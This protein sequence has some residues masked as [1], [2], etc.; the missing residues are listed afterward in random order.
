M[1]EVDVRVVVTDEDLLAVFD[2]LGVTVRVEEA[3]FDFVIDGVVEIVNDG[4]EGGSKIERNPFPPMA[5]LGPPFET[6]PPG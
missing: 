2:L 4:V 5:P 3:E 1:E 6:V